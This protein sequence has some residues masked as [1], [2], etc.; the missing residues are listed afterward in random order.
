MDD[1]TER[2]WKTASLHRPVHMHRQRVP[3][4]PEHSWHAAH[5][6]LAPTGPA[7]HTGHAIMATRSTAAAGRP[8]ATGIMHAAAVQHALHW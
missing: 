7:Q 1:E 6:E 2:A 3:G 8:A 4:Q 5:A